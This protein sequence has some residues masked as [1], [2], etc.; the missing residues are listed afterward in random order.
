MKNILKI[1]IFALAVLLTVSCEDEDDKLIAQGADAASFIDASSTIELSETT[2]N[3]SITIS[4]S[5]SN[6]GIATQVNYTIELASNGSEFAEP[7]VVAVTTNNSYTWTVEELNS[8]VIRAGLKTGTEGAVDLR[9][10]SSIG[11]DQFDEL[12]SEVA[13]IT[14]T[15]YAVFVV[16]PNKVWLPGG[17]ASASGYGADW[18]PSDP[19]TPTLAAPKEGDTNYEGYIYF[20]NDNSNFK[21]TPTD[22]G[23]DGNFGENDP[24]GTSGVLFRDDGSSNIV[25]EKGGYYRINA[26]TDKLTYTLTPTDWAVTGDATPNGWA[27]PAPDH[28]MV[29]DPA[30]KTW[31][32]TLD[33]TDAYIKFR[34]NDEWE[35]IFGG[36]DGILNMENDTDNRIKIESA[37]NY[38]IT[39]DL[40]N[41]RIYTYSVV[42]N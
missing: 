24:S 6:Y 34:A 23:F 38:T 17:Y 28:D 41:P 30:A 11:S 3:D 31:S 22:A 14:T 9:V 21:I 42:K 19:L 16:L 13:T 29:Y 26:D 39:I 20:A 10:K 32:T 1:S 35:E 37:G 12:I 2:A 5:K 27:D 25:V 40:S 36:A 15:P 33:L 7:I 8:Q 18:N 4:W